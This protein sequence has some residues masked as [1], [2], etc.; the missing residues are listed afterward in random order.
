MGRIAIG[1]AAVLA[2]AVLLASAASA[3]AAVLEVLLIASGADLIV[4]GWLSH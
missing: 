4:T 3:L 1:G 2:G